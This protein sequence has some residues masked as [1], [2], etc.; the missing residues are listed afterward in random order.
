MSPLSEHEQ[1]VL[2]E[3]EKNLYA[4]DP[5]YGTRGRAAGVQLVRFGAVTFVVGLAML[6]I[7]FL[8]RSLILG[9]LAFVAMVG[10]IFL[11]TT[12]I[13]QVAS[14]RNQSSLGA[15]DRAARTVEGWGERIRQRFKRD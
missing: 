14:A 12:G 11:V 7:F 9:V 15:R 8:S 4:D 6:F 5:R 2:D 3:I 13:R 10:G 1:K